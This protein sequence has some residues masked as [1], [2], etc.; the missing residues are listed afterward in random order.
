MILTLYSHQQFDELPSIGSEYVST[1]RNGY[2]QD[3][4][5]VIRRGFIHDVP[6]RPAHSIAFHL[7]F[8][9]STPFALRSTFNNS[10]II[11]E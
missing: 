7:N 10:G 3:V 4:S 8:L 1:H 6:M 9:C 2:K 11:E 5:Y